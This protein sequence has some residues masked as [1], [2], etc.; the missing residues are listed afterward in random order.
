M[1]TSSFTFQQF[2]VRQDRCA[3][4]VGT[5]GV[6]L[7]AWAEGGKRIL[8]VGTGTGLI[9]LMMAQRFPDASVV[10]IDIDALACQQAQENVADSPFA[11]RVGVSCVSLQDYSGP[12]TFDCIVANPPFF[13]NS[14]RNPDERK[15]AARHTDMLPFD[16]LFNG[17]ERLLS[18]DG[19]FSVIIPSDF[20]ERFISNAYISG[21]YITRQYDIKTT[22]RKPVKRCLLA[23]RKLRPEL[24]DRREVYLQ[25]VDGNRSAWYSEL[26][27]DFYL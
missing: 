9:A 2:S 22:I 5:D 6:L 10:G 16:D 19:V 25:D 15:A 27:R 14:L 26:M 12:D 24:L 3:M 20:L 18:D 1:S 8:D 7:G 21:F 23:F 11:G 13:E 17:V 4:K